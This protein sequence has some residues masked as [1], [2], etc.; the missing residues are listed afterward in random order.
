MNNTTSPHRAYR[1]LIRDIVQYMKY[2]GFDGMSG[3]YELKF[4]PFGK[5]IDE[6]PFW[7][8]EKIHFILGLINKVK[9]EK[10]KK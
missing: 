2:F 5:G 7:I 3:V 4:L 8:M 10:R 1:V 9:S 6:H